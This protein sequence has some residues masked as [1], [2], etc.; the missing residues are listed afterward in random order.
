[1]L[2]I[3]HVAF[4]LEYLYPLECF[5]MG[6][7][8]EEHTPLEVGKVGEVLQQHR[9]HVRQLQYLE[10]MLWGPARPL[11]YYDYGGAPLTFQRKAMGQLYESAVADGKRLV[12]EVGPGE[13]LSPL[14]AAVNR[15]HT[16]VFA[17]DHAY[18]PRERY[19]E[20][21]AKELALAA[22]RQKSL[23]VFFGLDGTTLDP[24]FRFD[25]VQMLFPIPENVATVAHKVSRYVKIGG[26]LVILVDPTSLREAPI[27]TITG[28]LSGEFSVDV[29]K[30]DRTQVKYVFGVSDTE[31]TKHD[32]T[33]VVVA[34]RRG[35][36]SPR[37]V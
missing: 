18:R 27:E 15:P 36:D 25:R 17:V 12:L 11:P 22:E 19:G 13:R 9:P 7:E 29:S 10:S 24:A 21:L 8:G 30:L 2:I 5:F 34:K 4:S 26:D 14:E 32:L 3:L 37:P 20:A 33:P 23:A 1:M 28:E 6:E 16:V 35:R 31:F